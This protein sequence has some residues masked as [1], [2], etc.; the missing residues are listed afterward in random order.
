MNRLAP[1]L[2]CAA[3][4]PLIRLAHG[5]SAQ[6]CNEIASALAYWV[7]AYAE[8]SWPDND[9]IA[10]PSLKQTMNSLLDNVE[11]P[12][13]R[14]GQFLVTD[15]MIRVREQ[16]S[17]EQLNFKPDQQNIS[18][19][20]MEESILELYLAS[21]DFTILHGVTGTYA[22]R[23]LLERFPSIDNLLIYLWQGLVTA[24]L[25]KGLNDKSMQQ[26]LD[27]LRD[28]KTATPESIRQ[29]ACQSMDDHSIKLAAVCLQMY[30]ITNNEKYLLAISRKLGR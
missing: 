16:A 4:H 12:A 14:L 11:W 27:Q 18:L 30:N 9:A 6:N 28:I 20:E 8:L 13:G 3:F 15:D 23:V 7:F 25:S 29:R 22:V 5:L 26:V 1:G 21:N 10:S 2:S 19:I 24:F 17:F